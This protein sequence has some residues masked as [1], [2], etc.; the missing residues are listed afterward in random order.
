[1]PIDKFGRHILRAAPYQSVTSPQMPVITSSPNTSAFY[2]CEPS[3]HH[4]KCIINIRGVENKSKK[5]SYYI[6]EN[7]KEEYIFPIS[8]KIESIEISPTNCPVSFGIKTLKSSDLIGKN[9][10]KGDIIRFR[11][12]SAS[13]YVEI[14]LQCPIE[15]NV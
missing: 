9:I 1:M 11:G 7:T 6:L 10:N 3:L 12:Q 13:L 14:V 5:H 2:I 8:G 4:S 15:K